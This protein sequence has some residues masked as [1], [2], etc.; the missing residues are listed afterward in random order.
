MR[1]SK[2]TDKEK[3][4]KCLI[5]FS[6]KSRPNSHSMKQ[7]YDFFLDLVGLQKNSKKCFQLDFDF[8]KPSQKFDTIETQWSQKTTRT[9]KLTK[10][11]H[12]KKKR[13]VSTFL[14]D[15][16]KCNSKM[17]L[18]RIITSLS[19]L[20]HQLVE[21]YMTQCFIFDIFTRKLKNKSFLLSKRELLF[22]MFKEPRLLEMD[23]HFDNNLLKNFCTGMANF[24]AR[25]CQK[26]LGLSFFR[27]LEE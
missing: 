22:K 9:K 13:E 3:L 26:M 27:S 11:K 2:T 5:S 1:C 7:K 23:C 15:L 14:G 4:K 20:C 16:K 6:K 21:F 10:I 8:P 12:K 17:G 18:R 24:L 25:H 19:P